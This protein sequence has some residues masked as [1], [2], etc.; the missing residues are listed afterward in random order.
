[1]RTFIFIVTTFFTFSVLAQTVKVVSIP[2]YTNYKNEVD[3]TLWFKWKYDLAKHINLKDL[4]TST[5]TFH[6]RF[7]TEVQA[8]DIW[9]SD[10]NTYFGLVTNFAQRYDDKLL[11][12][13][14]Y[15]VG[16]VYSKQF[17]LS[18]FKAKTL[19]NIIRQL[20]IDTIPSD[21]EIN[22]WKQG[23]DGVEFIIENSTPY[24]YDFKTY[25]T[26]RIFADSLVEAKNIQAFVDYLQYDFRIY[27]Y[28][29]SL[30]LPS[31]T[32]QRNGV[33]GIDIRNTN[34][35]IIR[36]TTIIDLLQ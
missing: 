1:M 19:F 36:G 15:K 16:K 21:N 30:K 34:Q 18:N 6:F 24:K 2:T 14:I 32:Y 29:K 31:G 10:H 20:S 11:R 9:T 28:Y 26:P 23:F 3:T 5:D 12:M 4:Q 27:D 25:W 33:Q 13:N 35:E 8:I 17:V 7:W 22:G